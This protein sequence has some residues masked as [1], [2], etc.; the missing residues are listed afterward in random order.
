MKKSNKKYNVFIIIL[1]VIGFSI[2]IYPF[3]SNYYYTVRNVENNINFDEERK[4][5]KKLEIDERIKKAEYYNMSLSP[6]LMYDP[7]LNEKYSE[8]RAEYARMLEINEQLGYIIIPKINVNL[9]VYA[10]TTESVLQIGVGHMEG[11]SLPIGGRQSHSVLTAHTGLPSAKLFTDLEKLVIGDV[12]YV[13]NI[14]ETLAYEVDNI[15]VAEP[16]DFSHIKIV[17]D[18]DYITLLTCTPYM[19]NSHRLLVRGHRI[20]YIEKNMTLENAV[21][22]YILIIYIICIVLI[23]I[24]L[25]I[26]RK[27]YKNYKKHKINIIK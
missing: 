5:L 20:P 22:K 4:N 9:S 15:V 12:F 7:Y 10:G 19:I 16:N 25:F 27:I 1:F 21:V 14:K 11:S 18:N 23:I 17:D 8:G 3:V 24:L 2:F 26:L 6:D 13:T